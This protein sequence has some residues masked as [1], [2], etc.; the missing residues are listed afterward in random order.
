MAEEGVQ[1]PSSLQQSNVDEGVKYIGDRNAILFSAEAGEPLPPLELPDDFFELKKDDVRAL[2]KELK[3]NREMMENSPFRTKAV[4]EMEENMAML[5]RLHSYTKTVL[6]IQFPDRLVLQAVFNHS[7]NVQ[8]VVEFIK[9]F[10]HSPDVQFQ[11][12]TAPPK[13]VLKPESTLVEA[14][15]TPRALVYFGA[16][17]TSEETTFLKPSYLTSLTS[18][19][20]AS[21]AAL[22][23]RRKENADEVKME[24]SVKDSEP[25]SSTKE[26]KLPSTSK[27]SGPK[28]NKVPKWFKR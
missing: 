6:R 14:K 16:I 15:L 20:Q 23:Y 28:S 27:T 8:T 19:K 12:Y 3:E 1:G 11:L 21:E 22:H 5:Q 17:P 24:E 2:F 26:S 18:P 10:L 13:C 9:Q 7:D 25:S 4:R